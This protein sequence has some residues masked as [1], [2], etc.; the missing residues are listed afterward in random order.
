MADFKATCHTPDN[1][2][3]DRRIQALGGS[4]WYKNIDNII[5]EIEGGINR[6]S[7]VAKGTEV[8]IVVAKRSNGR[9]YLKTETDGIEPDN[10]LALPKCS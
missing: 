5:A 3:A 1:N 8:R 6:F 4:G 7:A 10:L 9:K 2:D